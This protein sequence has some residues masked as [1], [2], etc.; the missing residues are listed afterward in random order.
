MGAWGVEV[1]DNDDA[2]DWCADLEADGARAIAQALGAALQDGYLDGDVG[3]RALAAADVLGR[4]RTGD[5]AL[6][7]AYGPGDWM[8]AQ[9]AAPSD[10]L[11]RL[12]ERAVDRVTGP[13]SELAE[14]WRETE[15]F[16]A[17]QASVRTVIG[18][19]L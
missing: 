7:S 9:S 13:D 2:A 8:R 17:W 16:G 4:L 18:R 14:L 1:Y 10:D 5:V 15:D 12:A 6:D 3:A 19:L 11:V